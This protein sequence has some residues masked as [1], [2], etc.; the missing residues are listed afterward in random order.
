MLD[1]QKI[2]N[3]L[4]ELR[5]QKGMTQ[6]Q[7]AEQFGTTSRSVSRW[8]NGSNLPDLSVLVELASFYD[9]ELNEIINGEQNAQEV[10]GETEIE[11]VVEYA[12]AD[13]ERLKKQMVRNNAIALGL[14]TIALCLYL[15]G[16]IPFLAD[17][18]RKLT[19]GFSLGLSLVIMIFNIL[20]FSGKAGCNR[21]GH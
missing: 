1:Q 17:E 3:Y 10:K 13:K 5:K 2:G 12:D 20:G 16:D 18:I 4:R 7:L 15:T 9:V 14:L 8:E 11:K 19:M 21:T 6:E